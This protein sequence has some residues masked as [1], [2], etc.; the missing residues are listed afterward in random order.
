MAGEQRK[1]S[2]K[3]RMEMFQSGV[4]ALTTENEVSNVRQLLRQRYLKNRTEED[5]VRKAAEEK[6]AAAKKAR[7]E[8]EDKKSK[9]QPDTSK[10]GRQLARVF[11]FGSTGSGSSNNTTRNR[12]HNNH[13]RGGGGRRP[14]EIDP[15]DDPRVLAENFAFDDL[16]DND[17]LPP[18]PPALP[19]RAPLRGGRRLGQGGEEEEEEE[20]IQEFPFFADGQGGVVEED[21]DDDDDSFLSLVRHFLKHKTTA[22]IAW[23]AFKLLLYVVL[24]VVAYKYGFGSVCFALALLIFVCTNL[25]NR[26]AGELSAYSVFNPWCQPIPSTVGSGQP[27]D[28]I[29]LLGQL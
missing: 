27:E 12:H 15:F 29:V 28:N 16:D 8:E 21:E 22:H 11:R 9:Q 20:D 3:E 7:E 25:R 14:A 6:E 10:L 26:R 17:V 13:H 1:L 4:S 5:E 19:V 18:R 23:I 2:N 24:Q